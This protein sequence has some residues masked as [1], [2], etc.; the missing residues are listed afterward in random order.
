[1]Y[2]HNALIYTYLFIL[3]LTQLGVILLTSQALSS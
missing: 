3:L 1:M 2:V